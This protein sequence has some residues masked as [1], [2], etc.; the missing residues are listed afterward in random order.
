MPVAIPSEESLTVEFKSDRK[1]L[2]DAELVA[3][4]LYLANVEGSAQLRDLGEYRTQRL[5]LAAW[6]AGEN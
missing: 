5:V 6:D 1:R 3:A 4:V 2:P